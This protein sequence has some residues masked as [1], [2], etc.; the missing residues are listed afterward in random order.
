MSVLLI[1]AMIATAYLVTSK[2]ISIWPHWI[3]RIVGSI[4]GFVAAYLLCIWIIV[5]VFPK[6][7]GAEMV[8]LV[9]ANIANSL[10]ADWGGT[11]LLFAG[12]AVIAANFMGL[13]GRK[14]SA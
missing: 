14:A 12:A 10:Y 13:R 5:D 8:D 7:G 2:I 9:G 6:V 4:A 3:A 1:G 11:G